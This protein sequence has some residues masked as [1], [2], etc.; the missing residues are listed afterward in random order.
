MNQSSRSAVRRQLGLFGC[1][2]LF[3][4]ACATPTGG[5]PTGPGDPTAPNPGTEPSAVLSADVLEGEV[6]LVVNFN[7]VTENVG[8]DARY[9][10][11]FADGEP[12]EGSRSRYHVFTVPGTY[13]AK[14][15]VSGTSGVV[16]GEVTIEALESTVP[17]NIS[18]VTPA[19]SLDAL[20]LDP[21]DPLTVTFVAKGE[22]SPDDPL[23]YL[24]DFGDGS[25]TTSATAE[26]TYAAPGLYVATVVVRDT[27]NE[28]AFAQ[29]ELELEAPAT[30]AE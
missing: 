21:E 15:A 2:S 6:P 18:N 13:T 17:R 20:A 3:L 9:L 28:V 29:A 5:A 12:T 22:D 1:L 26:H 16:E 27:H 14:V 10:W 19:V 4:A 8:E 23:S 25:R 11:T 30:S 24:L 7:T